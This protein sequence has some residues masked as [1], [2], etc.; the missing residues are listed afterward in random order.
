MKLLKTLF[1]AGAVTLMYACGPAE[2]KEGADSETEVEESEE[3]AETEM[4]SEE[5]PAKLMAK[6]DVA[7]ASGSEVTGEVTFTDMGDGKI[8]LK[9]SIKNASPGSHAIHLHQNGDC[10]ADDATSAGGHWNPAE[11]KHGNRAKDAKFHAGD[12]DNLEVGEDGAGTM[13]MVVEGWTI[14]GSD[15]TNILGKAVIIH[16]G[17]DDFESQPSGAAGARVA[18]GVIK[19]M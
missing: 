11:V 5:E 15:A 19:Q 9:V 14:G 18:C 8:E 2:K 13:E 7:G 3:M 4:E 6:A 16:A 17:A 12:I 1:L 10:S